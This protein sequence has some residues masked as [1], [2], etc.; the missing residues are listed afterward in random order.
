MKEIVLLTG[1]AGFIGSQILRDLLKEGYYVIG[2]DN[3]TE[4]SNPDNFDDNLA[5]SKYEYDI[6]SPALSDFLKS[7]YHYKIDY[8]IN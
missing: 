3:F 8:I 7:K 5:F 1:Y 2:V 6:S 4:G